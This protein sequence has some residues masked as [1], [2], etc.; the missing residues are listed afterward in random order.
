MSVVHT[1][2]DRL[3][4]RV[5]GLMKKALDTM[6]DSINTVNRKRRASGRDLLP[7]ATRLQATLG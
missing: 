6:G 4:K 5:P 1:A 7:S 2:A 3:S